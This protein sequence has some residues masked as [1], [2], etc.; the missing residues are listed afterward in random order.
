M[1][2]ANI[3]LQP[4]YN[5]IGINALINTGPDSKR[6]SDGII[7]RASIDPASLTA[8]FSSFSRA[9][10]SNETNIDSIFGLSQ[11]IEIFNQGIANYLAHV[12]RSFQY[13]ASC[14]EAI[15]QGNQFMNKI[16]MLESNIQLLIPFSMEQLI[17]IN[18]H[19]DQWIDHLQSVLQWQYVYSFQTPFI[20]ELNMIKYF[21]LRMMQCPD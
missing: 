4:F 17:V 5:T 11:Y 3:W 16:E 8:F 18:E 21:L 7:H 1:N 6:L 19:C 20:H 9:N 10:I 12:N 15:R 2:F 13:R 14:I